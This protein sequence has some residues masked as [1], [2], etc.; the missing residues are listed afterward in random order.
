MKLFL[1]INTDSFQ[2]QSAGRMKKI[3]AAILCVAVLVG[4]ALCG[5]TFWYSKQAKFHDVTVELG[6]PSVSLRDF[7]TEYARADKVGFVSDV[8]VIDLNRVGQTQL[9]LRYDEQEYTV[10]LTVQDTTAPA[11]EF[12]TTLSWWADSLPEASDFVSSVSDFSETS[13]QFEQ[14]PFV[15]E[16]YDDQKVLVIVEDTYGNRT[17][18]ECTIVWQW[19]RDNFLLELGDVLTVENLL[20]NP[21]R[22]AALLEQAELDRI[23]NADVGTYTIIAGT[24]GKNVTCTV[25]VQDTVG[26]VLQLQ[27]AQCEPGGSVALE[28]FVVSA[29]DLSGVADIRFVSEPDCNTAGTYTVQIEAED[30]LGNVTRQEVTLWVTNDPN[31]PVINGASEPLTVE[32]DTNPDFLEG[33]S[34]TDDISGECAVSVDTSGVNLGKPGTYFITYSAKDVAGNE[35]TLKRKVTVTHN[36]QDTADLV[37]RLAANVSE[38]PVAIRYF[39]RNTIHYSSNWGGEDPVWFGFTYRHGNCYV[40][41]LALKA[42]LELKGYETQLIWVTDKSHYWVLVNVDGVWWHLDATPSNLYDY[43]GL[44]N[45]STR[46]A[47]LSNRN[48]DRTQWPVCDGD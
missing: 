14:E 13:I 28:D 2:M 39:V 15:A 8:S 25:T 19:I 24:E 22:D 17:V 20:A 27:E 26:P 42:V 31:G 5:Y 33:V 40:H 41:A 38:D 43:Y 11:V 30:K 10:T 45:D 44:M 29:E 4:I 23:N 35:T 9:T 18:Q 37:A 46:F 32:R 34:A 16:G 12:F 1:K 3:T 36:A 48:W 6:T 21:E 47:T 7:M